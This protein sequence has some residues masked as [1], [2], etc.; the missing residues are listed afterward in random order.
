MRTTSS[1]PPDWFSANGNVVIVSGHSG[2]RRTTFLR[3][4]MDQAGPTNAASMLDCDFDVGGAWAGLGEIFSPIVAELMSSAPQLISHHD[5]ELV[6]VLPHLRR[7]IQVRNPSLTDIAPPDEKTRNYPADRALRIVHGLSDLIERWR[8]G[9][10]N[11]WLILCD[12]FESAGSFVRCFFSELQ[13]RYGKKL[14][15]TFVVT[16][17]PQRSGEVRGNFNSQAQ[18]AIVTLHHRPQLAVE[19]GAAEAQQLA[20]ELE[21]RVGEDRIEQQIHLAQLVH[22]W[23]MAGRPDKVFRWEYASLAML[24]NVGLYEDAIVYGERVRQAFEEHGGGDAEARWVMLVTLFMSYLAIRK[25]DEAYHLA[26]N[27][28]LVARENVVHKFQLCYLVAILHA[29]FLPKRDLARAEELLEEGLAALEAAHLDRGKYHFMY[30]FNRNALAL[31]RHLQGRYAEAIELCQNGANLLDANLQRDEYRLHRSVLLYNIAQ[32][33]DAIRDYENALKYYTAAMEMDP[34]YSEYYND[35][36]NVCL[37]T[38]RL[39]EAVEDYHKAIT[40]SPPYFE[41]WTNLGQSLRMLGRMDEAIA[42]YSQALDLKPDQPLC[43]LGRAQCLEARGLMK[44]AL[45]DYDSAL[46]LAP[47]QWDAL[48]SRAVI[49]YESGELASSLADL[50]RAIQLSPQVAVLYQ[51]RALIFSALSREEE[52]ASDLHA[53][54]RLSPDADDRA[55]VEDRLQQ[56]FRHAKLA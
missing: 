22:T 37:K 1:M 35:R 12:R 6:H 55:E 40:L 8:T 5:Y 46:A 2:R 39:V 27:D 24:N 34:N 45:A 17:A 54:L 15:I 20:E 25:V 42:A 4:L 7:V 52:A 18:V 56:L 44:E 31:V 16:A 13:R 32:V 28:M 14:R 10:T 9:S 49:L 41:V 53:Y 30:V 47:D 21:T 19:G 26:Q 36:G 3:G 11:D 29:R 50:D 43:L 51:N 23:R 48:A 38:G 33:Y